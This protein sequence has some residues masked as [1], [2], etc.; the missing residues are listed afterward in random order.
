MTELCGLRWGPFP[1]FPVNLTGASHSQESHYPTSGLMVETHPLGS[2]CP[3]CLTLSGSAPLRSG[4]NPGKT[5]LCG[6]QE[7]AIHPTFPEA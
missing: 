7:G 3:T 5:K 6:S 4:K 2:S 1:S